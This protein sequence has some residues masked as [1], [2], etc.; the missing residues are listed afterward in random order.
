MKKILIFCSA[1]L[2]FSCTNENVV[3]DKTP[4]NKLFSI[5]D[6]FNMINTNTKHRI[7]IQNYSSLYTENTLSSALIVSN[8]QNSGLFFSIN[9]AV[10]KPSDAYTNQ[11][12]RTNWNTDNLDLN[13][14]SGTKVNFAY[15]INEDKLASMPKR[16]VDLPLVLKVKFSNLN[17]DEKVVAG[18][19]I[20]WNKDVLNSKGVVLFIEYFPTSQFEQSI[21]L[22][23]PKPIVNGIT[24]EDNGSYTITA[25]DLSNYPDNAHLDFNIARATSTIINDGN[26]NNDLSV[27]A[28]SK[29]NAM[30]KIDKPK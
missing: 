24:V 4:E 12:N 7:L 29:V 21:A 2:L 10:F 1:L 19:I 11:E 17:K 20:N 15:G 8:N 27:V 13:K 22:A 26:A 3:I 6:Y 9:D 18:T 5:D 14:F 30:F 25:A 23:Y 16:T 28:F